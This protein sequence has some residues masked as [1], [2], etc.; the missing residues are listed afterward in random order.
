MGVRVE[1][2]DDDGTWGGFGVVPD[3]GELVAVV[4]GAELVG[5]AEVG[6]GVIVVG[7]AVVAGGLGVEAVGDA[8]Y[9]TE[10]EPLALCLLGEVA[11]HEP[12]PKMVRCVEPER[13]IPVRLSGVRNTKVAVPDETV[14][15]TID[16]TWLEASETR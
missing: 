9:S 11:P 13:V 8:G 1:V 10:L 2:G 14:E 16:V 15:L 12:I 3:G 4:A 5:E 7:D 6:G